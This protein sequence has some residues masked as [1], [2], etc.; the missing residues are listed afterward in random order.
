MLSHAWKSNPRIPRAVAPNFREMAKMF[1]AASVSV[2]IRVA[3]LRRVS[4]FFVPFRPKI[5]LVGLSDLFSQPKPRPPTRWEFLAQPRL[6]AGLMH[7][8]GFFTG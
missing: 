7:E 8:P 2:C 1:A 5:R 6:A 4:E 3:R